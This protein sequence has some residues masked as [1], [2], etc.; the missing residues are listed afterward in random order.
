M[1]FQEDNLSY[2]ESLAFLQK[3]FPAESNCCRKYFPQKAFSEQI[4]SAESQSFLQKAFSAESISLK[5]LLQNFFQQ[6][7]FSAEYIFYRKS[8]LSVKSI[9]CR[10]ILYKNNF[11]LKIFSQKVNFCKKHLAPKHFLHTFS[12]AES[13]LKAVSVESISAESIFYRKFFYRKHFLY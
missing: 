12:S 1:Y 13:L 7:A 2:A 11:L 5:Y 6:K 10:S 4:I 3:A 9:F 8:I